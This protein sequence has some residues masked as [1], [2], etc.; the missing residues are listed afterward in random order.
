MPFIPKTPGYEVPLPIGAM[1]PLAHVRMAPY[2]TAI[3]VG[4]RS[5]IYTAATAGISL[6]KNNAKRGEWHLHYASY[7]VQARLPMAPVEYYRI[8]PILVVRCIYTLRNLTF[9][10]RFQRPVWPSHLNLFSKNPSYEAPLLV[11]A[12]LPSGHVQWVPYVLPIE[13]GRAV[14]LNPKLPHFCHSGTT[15]AEGSAVFA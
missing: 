3:F 2:F 9:K 13:Y 7:L 14:V 8:H 11:D 1:L 10:V 15:S 4:H 12:M 5:H 6:R